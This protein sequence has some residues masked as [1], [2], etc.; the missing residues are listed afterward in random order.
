MEITQLHFDSTTGLIPAIIQDAESGRVLMLGYMNQEALQKTL[1]EGIV[2]F[3][4]RSKQRLWTKGETSGNTLRVVSVHD[5]C[6]H[7]TL[8]IKA[9][10]EGPTCHEGTVSC[11]DSGQKGA[12]IEQGLPF[13]SYLEDFL[14]E[15][16][17]SMPEGSYTSKMFAKGIDKLSQKVGEEAVE[18]VIASKNEDD[19]EFIYEAA[20]LVFHLM[21]LMVEKKIDFRMITNELQKRHHPN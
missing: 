16:K 18:T 2:T 15:R 21:M 20:D 11:F 17:S 8:L 14:K 13:L 1:S 9:Q 10:A 7:D 12:V 6:D 19:A 3:F 5:D 4:S